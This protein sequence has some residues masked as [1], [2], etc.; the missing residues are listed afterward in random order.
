MYYNKYVK[1]KKKYYNLCNQYGG[2]FDNILSSLQENDIAST[3]VQLKA[4]ERKLTDDKA[5]TLYNIIKL[6]EYSFE[7]DQLI[8]TFIQSIESKEIISDIIFTRLLFYLDNDQDKLMSIYKKNTLTSEKNTE[9]IEIIKE[10]YDIEND[11]VKEL[12]DTIKK[13][14]EFECY[15]KLEKQYSEN[16][17]QYDSCLFKIGIAYQINLFKNIVSKDPAFERLIKGFMIGINPNLFASDNAD[18]IRL[19]NILINIFAQ[20]PDKNIFESLAQHLSEEHLHELIIL[21][22][23]EYSRETYNETIQIIHYIHE[24]LKISEVATNE[25]NSL[26]KKYMLNATF[27]QNNISSKIYKILYDNR[28]W[29]QRFI[30][31]LYTKRPYTMMNTA[32]RKQ[33]RPKQKGY[34]PV[35]R[36]MSDE[37][38]G[39]YYGQDESDVH[40]GGTFYFYDPSSL[41]YLNLGKYLFAPN[42]VIAF[43]MLIDEKGNKMKK[44]GSEYKIKGI[45]EQ[46][47]G[48]KMKD[49]AAR[50]DKSDPNKQMMHD[51]G[52]SLYESGTLHINLGNDK[53]AKGNQELKKKTLY[54]ASHKFKLIEKQIIKKHNIKYA[55]IKPGS[56]RSHQMT[57]FIMNKII[58][59]IDNLNEN[60]LYEKVSDDPIDYKYNVTDAEMQLYAMFDYLDQV[61]NVYGYELGY[62]TIILQAEPGGFKGVT[63]ILD[64]RK[65]EDSYKNLAFGYDS[66]YLF[67]D[68]IGKRSYDI[69][70][71][72]AVILFKQDFDKF[73]NINQRMS[74]KY[75]D[76]LE[77]I[78]NLYKATKQDVPDMNKLR[79]DYKKFLKIGFIQ[80][81][82]WAN[83]VMDNLRVRNIYLQLFNKIISYSDIRTQL[84]REI[85]I[86]LDQIIHKYIPNLFYIVSLDDFVKIVID[87][88][89]IIVNYDDLLKHT[90]F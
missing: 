32:Y 39:H 12:F 28:L 47:E 53:N 16:N 71:D 55:N 27:D 34:L 54:K 82:I 57:L 84:L 89:K 1:Y 56:R 77:I 37:G 69:W 3:L 65:R 4:I 20:N 50:L 38:R 72:S 11:K 73:N 70:H 19:I 10:R 26:M 85:N 43:M 51:Q 79:I 17:F 31:I 80:P 18:T 64:V 58:K 67:F 8:E 13:D 2:S 40:K 83:E 68:M 62:D 41:I 9:I 59:N 15:I 7:L 63:E 24:N 23:K 78:D 66:D 44:E 30:E 29:Y 81:H 52:T 74:R 22:L 46:N 5:S 36:Y 75:E 90:Q 60:Y 35:V 88:L 48:L 33:L 49:D 14:K 86:S 42:K 6:K 25:M 87:K 61:L 45:A 76:Y 21:L